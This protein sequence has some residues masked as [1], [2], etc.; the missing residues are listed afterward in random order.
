MLRNATQ[1]FYRIHTVLQNP[2]IFFYSD[3]YSII[4]VNK[5]W[6]VVYDKINPFFRL[7]ISFRKYIISTK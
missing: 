6:N 4:N 5:N 2:N 1:R 3:W 7:G